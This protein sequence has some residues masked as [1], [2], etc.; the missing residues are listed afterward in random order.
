MLNTTS[1]WYRNDLTNVTNLRTLQYAVPQAVASHIF[2]VHPTTRFNPNQPQNAHGH[3]SVATRSEHYVQART[4]KTARF[5]PA[6]TVTSCWNTTTPSCLQALYN[7]NPKPGSVDTSGN[8]NFGILSFLKQ[9]TKFND[10]AL[11]LSNLAPYAVDSNFTFVS[12][13]GVLDTQ[14]DTVDRDDEA[15]GDIEYAVALT[16]PLAGYVLHYRRSRSP[17]SRS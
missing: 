9:Y 11:F 13:S 5:L 15:D 17:R 14:N 12:I 16:H 7:I 1:Q 4:S 3:P 2:M 8:Q 6:L 10:L